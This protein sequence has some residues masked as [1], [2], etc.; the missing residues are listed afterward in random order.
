LF[1]C[2]WQGDGSPKLAKSR[3]ALAVHRRMTCILFLCKPQHIR[4]AVCC[5]L[6]CQSWGWAALIHLVA[7]TWSTDV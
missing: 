3:F 2:T 5:L 1:V 6:Q 7:C 4:D